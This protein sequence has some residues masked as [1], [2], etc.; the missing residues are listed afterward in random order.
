MEKRTS[1][2]VSGYKAINGRTKMEL[3]P[4]TLIA[5]AN[6]SGKSSFMQ[7]F[8]ILKQTAE[9]SFDPGA[10]MPYGPNVQLTDWAQTLSRGRTRDSLAS[11]MSI[12]IGFGKESVENRYRWTVESGMQ[13][14]STSISKNGKSAAIHEGSRPSAVESLLKIVDHPF[15]GMIENLNSDSRMRFEFGASRDRCFIDPVL[16]TKQNRGVGQVAIGGSTISKRYQNFL[17]SLIHVPGLRGNPLRTYA[18]SAVDDSFP[19]TMEN[20]IASVIAHWQSKGSSGREKLRHLSSDL[21]KL[22]LTWKVEARKINDASVE[23]RVGRLPHAQAGGAQDLVNI[24]DVGFGVS[25]TLPVLVALHA[26]RPGQVVY[27]EQPEIHLHPRA[28]VGMGELLVDAACRG[29]IVV[30]E[31]HSSLVLR[32]VQTA[33]ANGKI[34]SSDV[35]LNWF[36]RDSDTGFSR[37]SKAE[38]DNLGRFGDW[39]ID[40]DEVLE[41]SDW[42]YVQAVQRSIR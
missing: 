33:I 1:L 10:L 13:I 16:R 7:P 42:R 3:S 15:L 34:S 22:G 18:S 11:E 28:Q 38:L 32:S 39:P 37:I 30:A 17:T 40:F 24:A 35:G 25:Q 36:S 27:V 12:G 41:D 4:L 14:V 2:S 21:E 20:Y 31:T 6:S 5:G 26:A 8:L 9:A 23:L 29:V 19:G